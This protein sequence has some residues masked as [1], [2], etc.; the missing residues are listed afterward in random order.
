MHVKVEFTT[1]A[2]TPQTIWALQPYTLT[3]PK[4]VALA[5][6]KDCEYAIYMNPTDKRGYRS[7]ARFI[8]NEEMRSTINRDY[9]RVEQRGLSFAI[10]EEVYRQKVPIVQTL[11]LV[12]IPIGLKKNQE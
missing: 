12:I 1:K 3:D 8:K 5:S 2:F 7:I 9:T 6:Y 10:E 11:R 4:V